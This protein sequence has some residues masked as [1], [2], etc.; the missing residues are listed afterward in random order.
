MPIRAEYLAQ[1][2]IASNK[3]CGLL[4]AIRLK[5][6]DLYDVL[7]VRY[8]TDFPCRGRTDGE[9]LLDWPRPQEIGL[10]VR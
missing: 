2:L 10:L 5:V 8:D 3:P 1:R 4:A 7:N 9:L 6:P